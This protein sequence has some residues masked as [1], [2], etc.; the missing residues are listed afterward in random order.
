MRDASLSDR[1]YMVQYIIDFCGIDNEELRKELSDK[2]DISLK[3]L[4]L[5]TKFVSEKLNSPK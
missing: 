4:Y 5:F 1:T 3:E 2:S